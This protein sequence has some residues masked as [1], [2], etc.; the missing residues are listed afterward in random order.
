MRGAHNLATKRLP[1]G[2]M[3][4]AHAEDRNLAREALNRLDGNTSL[5]WST[6]SRR[7]DNLLRREVGN[8]IGRDLIIE[9]DYNLL[10]HLAQVLNQI[11]CE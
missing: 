5:V 11:V 10:P 8:I 4:Q 6:R 9:F 7:D 2:L 1:N 3:S